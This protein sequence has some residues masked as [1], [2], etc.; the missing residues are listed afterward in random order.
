M[1]NEVSNQIDSLDEDYEKIITLI[2]EQRK[3]LHEEVDG[4]ISKMKNQITEI[5]QE[6]RAILEK[7]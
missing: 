3:T 2:S 7:D 4:V 6:H 5:K 1:K